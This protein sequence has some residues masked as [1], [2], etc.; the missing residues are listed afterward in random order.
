MQNSSHGSKGA[1]RRVYVPANAEMLA[2]LAAYGEVKPALDVHTVTAWLKG[3]APGA[4]VEDL[5]YTAFADAALSSV[6]LLVN[7]APRRV[8]ISA[9]VPGDLVED[10][11]GGTAAGFEGVVHL[12]KVAAIHIDDAAAAVQI[13]A[14]LD[15]GEPDLELIEANVLD[16]YAPEEFQELLAA[17]ALGRFGSSRP[18]ASTAQNAPA[19]IAVIEPLYWDWKLRVR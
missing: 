7:Q 4:D 9:D 2:H 6:A 3:E 5:E 10:R 14:E 15:S 1:P 19:N 16:W 13:A 11:P 18:K 8:V 12:K 17:L